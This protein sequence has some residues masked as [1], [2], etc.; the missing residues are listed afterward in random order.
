[1]QWSSLFVHQ[2]N[3]DTIYVHSALLLSVICHLRWRG[4]LISALFIH[5]LLIIFIIQHRKCIRNS[6][7]DRQG[8]KAALRMA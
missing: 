8:K 6:T 2:D 4:H 7:N 1:M 3:C 5:D